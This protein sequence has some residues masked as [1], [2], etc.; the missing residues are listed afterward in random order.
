MFGQVWR[1]LGE[2]TVA[3]V[4]AAATHPT[5]PRTVFSA[6]KCPIQNVSGAKAETLYYDQINKKMVK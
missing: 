6:Q 1:H 2:G 4:R 3:G 5:T